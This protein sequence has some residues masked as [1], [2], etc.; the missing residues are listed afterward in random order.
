MVSKLRT[1]NRFSFSVRMKRSA[2]PLPSGSPHEARGAV[3][4]E[5][6]DLL[7]EVVSQVVGPVVVPQTQPAGGA[8]GP[9]VLIGAHAAELSTP[10]GDEPASPHARS[11]ADLE[12][13]EE[14]LGSAGREADGERRR[15]WGCP[16]SLGDVAPAPGWRKPHRERYCYEGDR[17]RPPTPRISSGEA[18]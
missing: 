6:G 11:P 18:A 17:R 15:W 9:V 16:G 3:D 8:S 14:L 4:A 7:L 13:T 1:H 10:S 5:E 12:T 2:T